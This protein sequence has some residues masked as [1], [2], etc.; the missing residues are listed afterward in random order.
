MLLQ[1]LTCEVNDKIY[2]K[3]WKTMRDTIETGKCNGKLFKVSLNIKKC[4]NVSGRP[5]HHCKKAHCGKLAYAK[6]RN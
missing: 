3:N 6:R 5:L 1:Q 4:T 2:L